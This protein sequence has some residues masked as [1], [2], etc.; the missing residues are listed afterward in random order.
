[1]K[2]KIKDLTFD[3]L[4]T[5]CQKNQ[6][7]CEKCPLIFSAKSNIFCCLIAYQCGYIPKEYLGKEV[8]L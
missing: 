1:M 2:K 7:C 3:D 5:I 8:S 6:K 4:D